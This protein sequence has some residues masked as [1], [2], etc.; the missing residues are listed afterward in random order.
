MSSERLEKWKIDL[1]MPKLVKRSTKHRE[2]SGFENNDGW[3]MN[4]LG[5]YGH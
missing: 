5:F 2:E 1:A 4:G 3:F